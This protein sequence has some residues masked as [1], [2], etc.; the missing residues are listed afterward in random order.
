MKNIYKLISLLL[1]VM[2]V[3]SAMTVLFT[4]EVFAEDGTETET[5]TSSESGSETTSEEVETVEPFDYLTSYFA[6]PEEKLATMKLAYKIG[7]TCLYVD[8]YSGEVAYVNEKTGEKL[9]SNPYDVASTTGNEATK[10]EILSQ[11]IVEYKK[12]TAS[13]NDP[14]EKLTSYLDAAERGQI[15]VENIKGGIR[16]EYAIGREQS[17]ML[18]PRLITMERF[19]EMILAPLLEEF[20]S[21]LYNPRSQNSDV[22]DVQKMLSYYMVYSV[23]ALDRSVYSASDIK[24]ME[25]TFGG[26]F[27]NLRDSEAQYA[28]TLKQF[29]VIETMDVYV[30]DPKAGDKELARAE[31]IITKYCPEYTYEELAYDHILTDY[32]SDDSNP[33]LFRM[34]LEYKITDDGLEVTLPANGIRFN[35]SLYTLEAIQI[36]PY[37]GAGN[38]AYN[39]YNFFPDGSGALFDFKGYEEQVSVEGKVYGDDFTRSEIAGKYQNAIRYPVFGIVEE[40]VYYTYQRYNREG[41]KEGE[42]VKLA[43]NIV[44]AIKALDSEDKVSFCT[45]QA[46]GLKEKYSNVIY[47]SYSD[48]NRIIEKRGFLCI[49]EEGDALASITTLNEPD[50][51]ADYSTIKVAV[52]PRPKDKFK[53]DGA[54]G[55]I[56]VVSERK[57]VGNY[58]MKYITLSDADGADEGVQVYDASWFGMAVAYR[59]YLTR[60]GIISRLSDDELTSDI[61][62]YIETFG[63]IETTEKILSIPVTVMAPLTTFENVE[64]IYN[65]L[66]ADGMKNIN[67]KLT[68]YAN[69]GMWYTIPGNLKFEKA[70][71]GNDGFQ[72]LLDKANEVNQD[73]DS[74]FGIFPDFDFAFV[75]D[76]NIFSGYSAYKHNAKTIDDRYA[77]KREWSATQQKY[78][79]YFE[80]VVSPAYFVEFYEKLKK[81]YADKYEGVIGISVSTLG[82][83]LNSDFDED[84]PYNREDSKQH[85]VAAFQ[86]FSDTYG[87]VMT[88]GG[89]A[90]TW[91]YVDHMLG[92]ALDSSRYNFASRSV[93][94]IGVVL[95]GSMNFAG[96]PLNMEGDLQYAMLK[97]IENGASPYFVLSFQN[98][99][100][101]KEDQQLSKY[102]SIRYDI[103][104]NDINNTYAVLNNV[105]RDVQNKYIIGHEFL[106]GGVRIPDAEELMEDILLQYELLL[107]SHQNAAD[108][109]AKELK[110]AASIARE[111]GRLAEEYAAEAVLKV[112]SLYNTQMGLV[113]DAAVFSSDYYNNLKTV[114]DEYSKLTYANNAADKERLTRIN[115]LYTIIQ[116]HNIALANCADLY[117][118]ANSKYMSYKG[119]EAYSSYYETIVAVYNNYGN[120]NISAEQLDYALEKTIAEEML[121]S[122]ISAFRRGTIDKAALIDVIN[123]YGSIYV[124][125]DAY[126][127]AVN[128]YLSGNTAKKKVESLAE[129]FSND[130]KNA[131]KKAA[132]EAAIAAYEKNE[133]ADSAFR[134]SIEAWCAS[135]PEDKSK[136]NQAYLEAE[137]D[138]YQDGGRKSNLTNAIGM[139]FLA[140]LDKK[141]IMDTVEELIAAKSVYDAAQIKYKYGSI[142]AEDLKI[143]HDDLYGADELGGSYKTYRDQ[144][145]GFLNGDALYLFKMWFTPYHEDKVEYDLG[146]ARKG[147]DTNGAEA[148][149][150]AQKAIYDP[151]C[152]KMVYGACAGFDSDAAQADIIEYNKYV[153]EYFKY[154]AAEQA[155]KQAKD[156]GFKISFDECF[157]VYYNKW[158][159]EIYKSYALLL[160][161]TN[162]S[163]EA[164]NNYISYYDA[165]VAVTSLLAKVAASKVEKGSFEGYMEALAV[166]DSL[167]ANREILEQYN[168]TK[169]ESDLAHYKD[170]VVE[171]RRLA[172]SDASGSGLLL[173]TVM[174]TIIGAE[175]FNSMLESLGIS[176]N[177][178][179]L[180]QGI[181]IG[182]TN[183]KEMQAIYNEA[184]K[185][186]S[187]AE[188]A[189]YVIAEAAGYEIKYADGAEKE[190]VNI[191]IEE[192]MPYVVKQAIERAK[193]TYYYIEADSYAVIV[194]GTPTGDKHEGH[195]VYRSLTNSN[196]YYYGTYEEGYQYLEKIGENQY[197]VY[198][199]G[200]SNDG[201]FAGNVVYTNEEVFGAGVYFTTVGG[202]MT[203]Y[204]KTSDG[205]YVK[206]SPIEYNG[207]KVGTKEDQGK[208][209]DIY[210]DGDVYYSYDEETK[211]YTRYTYTKSIKN[212]YEEA[213]KQNENLMACLAVLNNNPAASDGRVN[214]DGVEVSFIKD[215]LDRILVNELVSNNEDAVV[216]EEEK[217]KYDTDNIVAVTYGNA[218]GSVYK[219]IILNY[220]NYD[221]NI[222]YM[223]VIYT[224]PAYYFVVHDED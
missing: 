203:Y 156:S 61:P 6:T 17:K 224:I 69:G 67:F 202:K 163:E 205:A 78:V 25:N 79:N 46:E 193:N 107:N 13:L 186:V 145:T 128:D 198:K 152:K 49:I 124:S 82:S 21:E 103:W 135:I 22:F 20:G 176:T 212:C 207:E 191:I 41:A 75:K 95:H 19:E 132:F 211:E 111:N 112:M 34:A 144:L 40:T 97:A 10:H 88:D 38:T 102:Y 213:V 122:A 183:L 27:E 133:L 26:L 98:T 187:I 58:K 134:E 136:Y 159:H 121:D 151:I 208:I 33:P 54:E 126:D 199:T 188:E 181:A 223:G 76:T 158:S 137:I 139:Y 140:K 142:S 70:V 47:D 129:A 182:S 94:F 171:K 77:S 146:L 120:G 168:K 110:E 170:M 74:N 201:I 116:T 43:G 216:D 30:F 118:E 179:G 166:Y 24:N 57:Y 64:T 59:D 90:Y 210:K 92:V 154:E 106:S 32:Q 73:A 125:A 108:L 130:R 200:N 153:D 71:G 178:A 11:I 86:H 185:K 115:E 4:V 165:G 192:N 160:K 29:P 127:T 48:V 68:G 63:T 96:K 105:L 180:S 197:Q 194:D 206:K 72:E 16:V 28:R 93:P 195:D 62:L 109:I 173:S 101:L 219:T 84:E 161:N 56:P 45:G 215:V 18:V 148:E 114:Y 184:V 147:L 2:M 50:A 35:E 157:E 189:I 5:G 55:E 149:Y 89:N 218:D 214:A 204:V 1:A 155:W 52:T 100:V 23:D 80:M 14:T 169:L 8:S 162:C 99:E 51:R 3:L 12:S 83:V 7:D 36:L 209:I 37:M 164:S 66:S 175:S 172:L 150:N 143:L 113:N 196:L 42:A 138:K 190:F 174:N 167:V 220:N 117:D 119:G 222:E 141:Q 39:G 91:K 217:S 123:K 177:D 85:T 53:L 15:T 87:Q 104:G 65:E 60:N 131:A 31:E 9:F 44:E 81:N 221:V